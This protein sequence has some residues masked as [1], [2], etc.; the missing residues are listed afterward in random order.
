MPII[1]RDTRKEFTPAPEGLHQAVC[2]DVVDLG[3][4]QTPWGEKSQV[5]IRWQLDGED[6]TR[7]RR[8]MVSKR[9]TL[10]LNEKA[11]LR[12]HLEAWRGRKFTPKELEGFDLEVLLG[13]N[14]QVQVVHVLTEKGN[15]FANVQ[16]VVPLGKGMT[17]MRPS[18]EYIR[19]VDRTTPTGVAAAPADDDEV[20]F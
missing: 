8:Y 6:E 19:V 14:G 3:L 13:V 20:P 2:C 11:T 17:K 12:Q 1:A 7:E 5:E 10:S 4:V 15:I 18:E 9:Y 16:A